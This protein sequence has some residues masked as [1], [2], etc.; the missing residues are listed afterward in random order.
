MNI[1][2]F[3]DDLSSLEVQEL[4]TEHLAGM[5]RNSPAGHVNALAIQNL[6]QADITLLT[7]WANQQLCGCGAIKELTVL[8]GEVKSMRTQAA[9]LRQ[10]VGQALL[11]EI[12]KTAKRR[13]YTHLYLETGTG[14]AFEAAHSL[15]KNNG[16]TWCGPFGNYTATDF[17]VFM[18]KTL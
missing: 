16:F 15:Y 9:Y 6:K 18:V 17:N 8:S 13:S 7:A 12:I 11:N 1:A 10:G 3:I 5:Q 14:E 2:I 4:I